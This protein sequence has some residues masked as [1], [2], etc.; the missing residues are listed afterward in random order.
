MKK[1]KSNKSKNSIRFEKFHSQM[2]NLTNASNDK[3]N[4]DVCLTQHNDEVEIHR[5][6]KL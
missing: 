5:N 4:N 2:Q 1:K 3:S 6:E